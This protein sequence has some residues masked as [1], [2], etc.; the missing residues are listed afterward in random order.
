LRPANFPTIRIAQFAALL[1]NSKNIFS[2]LIS[3]ESY[4]SIQ[5]I[6]VPQQ[7]DYWK[8]HYRFG[9]KAKGIVPELGEAS[10]QN[11]VINTVA[12]LLVAYG[13]YK[14]EQLCIDRAMESKKCI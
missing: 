2:Q 10:I 4:T 12:P 9:K 13:K 8:S 6:F 1:F 5:R 11:I 7:S 14:D 3:I